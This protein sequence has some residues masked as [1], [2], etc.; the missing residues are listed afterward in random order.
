MCDLLWSDP[1][2]TQGW[3][4]SPRGAGYLFGSDVV[5]QFNTA[6]DIEMIC[7]AHQV[8]YLLFYCLTLFILN[9]ILASHTFFSQKTFTVNLQKST[10]VVP[11]KV[12]QCFKQIIIKGLIR[13][14]NIKVTHF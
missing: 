5:S 2:D 6:N 8:G 13:I 12:N 3:G 11:R 14:T 10:K 4:V 7:R 9:K 1:E